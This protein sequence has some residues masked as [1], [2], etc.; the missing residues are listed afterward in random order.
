MD[1]E[2]FTKNL[3]K[4]VTV[5][6]EAGEKPDQRVS[7]AGRLVLEAFLQGSPTEIRTALSVFLTLREV[8]GPVADLI[9]PG[10]HKTA[11][12]AKAVLSGGPE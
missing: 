8:I 12:T 2:T 7:D 1:K 4:A 10:G 5:A 6:P 9:D 3:L 11:A